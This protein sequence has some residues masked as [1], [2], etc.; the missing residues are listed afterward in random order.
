[1][2]LVE[3]VKK[4]ADASPQGRD[5][6]IKVMAAD[7]DYWPL[8]WYLRSFKN[9]W[10]WDQIL[11]D[12]FAPIMV[13]SASFHAGLD[14]KKTHLMNGYFQLRPQNFLELYVSLDTWLEY[15]KKYPPKRDE[16]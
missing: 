6:V 10:Y 9:V 5:T 8:P 12:P 11:P 2:E 7:A 16:E 14:E 15:L 13:V 4:I 1:L 3:R